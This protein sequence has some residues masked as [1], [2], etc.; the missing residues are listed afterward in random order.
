MKPK[1]VSPLLC[2]STQRIATLSA[3]SNCLPGTHSCV[4][5]VAGKAVDIPPTF[6]SS[7]TRAYI[8]SP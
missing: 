6:L 4:L 1:V 3:Q 5:A 7:Y 8:Y 2:I